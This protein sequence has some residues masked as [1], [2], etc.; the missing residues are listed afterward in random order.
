MK[1]VQH[2]QN[3]FLDRKQALLQGIIIIIIF[4]NKGNWKK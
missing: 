1:S 3:Q 2:F 4:R